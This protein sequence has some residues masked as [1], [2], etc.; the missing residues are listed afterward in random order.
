M[1]TV[2]TSAIVLYASLAGNL[3]LALAAA[4]YAVG[5]RPLPSWYWFVIGAVVVLVAAQVGSGL[6]LLVGGAAPR[7]GLHLMY[8][9]LVAVTGAIQLG[10]RPGGFLRRRYAGDLSGS[11]ARILALLSLTAFALIARAWMT[12][13]G[14]R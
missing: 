6:A 7:R 4:G 10:L 5:R 14:A 13:V 12:G 1:A 11:D 2:H 9:A 8:G 3:F